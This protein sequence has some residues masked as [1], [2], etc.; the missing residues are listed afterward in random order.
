MNRRSRSDSFGYALAVLCGIAIWVAADLAIPRKDPLDTGGYWLVLYPAAILAAALVAYRYPR[1][2][3]VIALLVFEAQFLAMSVRNGGPGNLW[4]ISMG[5]FAVLALP[6]FAVS[7]W[8]ARRS[9]H[10]RPEDGP[11]G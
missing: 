4:P 8:A 2:P 6:A 9:P 11:N 7:W 3:G 5:I 1:H 10:R